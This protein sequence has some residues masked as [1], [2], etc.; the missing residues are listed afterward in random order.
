MPTSNLDP[1]TGA[2]YGTG[3]WNTGGVNNLFRKVNLKVTDYFSATLAPAFHRGESRIFKQL[4]AFVD[5]VVK[6]SVPPFV[7]DR[8]LHCD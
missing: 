5:C 4:P 3:A 1:A 7:K 8:F 6:G 2:S